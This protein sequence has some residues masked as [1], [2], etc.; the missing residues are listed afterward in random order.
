MFSCDFP[1]EKKFIT[2]C[3]HCNTEVDLP[4]VQIVNILW[5]FIFRIFKWIRIVNFIICLPVLFI[6]NK[7]ENIYKWACFIFEFFFFQHQIYLFSTFSSYY[8]WCKFYK[9]ANFAKRCKNVCNDRNS[10][11]LTNDFKYIATEFFQIAT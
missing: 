7:H 3:D 6:V 2:L 10:W 4:V 9:Q 8:N 5:I 11:C 1:R